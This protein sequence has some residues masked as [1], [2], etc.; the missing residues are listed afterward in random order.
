MWFERRVLGFWD[1]KKVNNLISISMKIFVCNLNFKITDP[2]LKNVFEDFGV[3]EKCGIV[4]DKETGK[5]KGFAFIEMSDGARQAINGLNG[6]EVFG[7]KIVVK[8][9][10]ERA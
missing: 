1:S 2:E 4:K 10:I 9:A 6:K 8:E 7:R 3:V 5:S